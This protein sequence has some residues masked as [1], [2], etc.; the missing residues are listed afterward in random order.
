MVWV[1]QESVWRSFHVYFGMGV[2]GLLK[3]HVKQQNLFPEQDC[4]KKV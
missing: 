4:K 1:V 3:F 2:I